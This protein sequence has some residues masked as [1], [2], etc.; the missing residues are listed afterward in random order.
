MAAGQFV[1]PLLSS[2]VAS[3][4]VLLQFSSFAGLVG[5]CRIFLRAN[6]IAVVKPF[7]AQL[8]SGLH[9]KAIRNTWVV[10]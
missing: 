5:A 9:G 3:T 8:P 4:L 10:R 6:F 1:C 7:S 2:L